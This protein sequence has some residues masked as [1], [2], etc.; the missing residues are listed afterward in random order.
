[1][2]GVRG[3]LFL[4]VIVTV[5]RTTYSCSNCSASA[6]SKKIGLVQNVLVP[7]K[8]PLPQKE[9]EILARLK[10]CRR[11]LE[12]PRRLFAKAAALDSSV[13]IRL[14]LGRMPLRFGVARALCAAHSI[15]AEWLA[16]GEDEGNFITPFGLPVVKQIQANDD[17]LFSDVFKAVIAPALFDTSRDDDADRFARMM[18]TD[19]WSQIMDNA[20]EKVSRENYAALDKQLCALL[21][22][23]VGP[24]PNPPKLKPF[25]QHF[26]A[27]AIQRPERGTAS[28]NKSQRGKFSVDDVTFTANMSGVK[29]SLQSLIERLKKVTKARG[30]KTALAKVLGV[31]LVNVSQWLSGVREPG[32][33]TTLKLLNWVEQQE[34]QQ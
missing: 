13:I 20:F 8:T 10:S 27:I 2:R 11:R 33:A 9:L 15:N 22:N 3:L 5:T 28:G 1:M 25:R 23:L 31:P 4:P 29:H 12:L 30:K 18:L 7:R 17:A 26:A 6:I 16:T 14:E 19:F 21:H 24:V 34:R 32:G